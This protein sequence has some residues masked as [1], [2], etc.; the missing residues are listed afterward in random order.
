MLQTIGQADY[1]TG[2][3]KV[4]TYNLIYDPEA[5]NIVNGV[6]QGTHGIVWLD[7]TRLDAFND[8]LSDT[9]QNQV[10]WA[11]GL[12]GI[13]TITNYVLNTGY[14]MNWGGSSWRLPS[15]V[16]AASSANYPPPASSSE[17]AHLYYAEGVT[18]SSPSPF[19]NLQSSYYWSGTEYAANSTNA[20][21]FYTPIGWQYADP[22]G[23][24][25]SAMA[26]RPGQLETSAV[27]EP[28]TYLLLGIGLGVVGYVRRRMSAR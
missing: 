14:S 15:T 7:Y 1:Y 8:P 22:K 6:G 26:V 12:N 2:A 4:G 9:W 13:G 20:W 16:D 3:T 28:S 25:Y 23:V 27:P 19:A 11:T 10:A 24:N 21:Y 17:M 5:P 18:G